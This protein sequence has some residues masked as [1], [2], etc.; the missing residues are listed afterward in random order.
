MSTEPRQPG[1]P[2]DPDLRNRREEEILTTAAQLFAKRGYAE[3]QVQTIADALSVGNGTIYRYFPTKEKLFLA[4]V[5]RG[6]SELTEQMHVVLNCDAEP[7]QI[8]RQAIWT[9]FQFF[10]TR[11]HMA[12]LFIQERAA[13]REHHRPLYFNEKNKQ[14]CD[15]HTR[16]FAKLHSA[17]LVQEDLPQESFFNVLGDLLYG[18]IITNLLTGRV[19][20]PDVQ[21][22]EILQVMWFGM[23]S[24]KARQ[25]FRTQKAKAQS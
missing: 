16:F 18:T 12:E 20:H 22:E 1:R 23:L 24:N 4:A 17:G 9:Y 5:E 7:L 6:L 21:T 11:P 2:E 10:Y 13:F 14:E 25:R 3:T 8:M 15:E 19:V